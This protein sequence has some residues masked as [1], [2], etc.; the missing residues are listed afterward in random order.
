MGPAA[1][2]DFYGKLVEETPAK[3]DQD[4]L[5]VVIW[6]DP[7]VPD[8]SES[9]LGRGADPTPWLERGI[10]TLV[11]AGCNVLAV[12]CNTAHA[13]VP[14]LAR[15]AGIQLVSI[16]ETTVDAIVADGA[17]TVGLLA[18]TGTLR[19]RL[20]TD[21]L[22]RRHVAV[23]EP[24]P[25]DQERVMAA[26]L[27]VKGGRAGPTHQQALADVSLRLAQRGAKCLV[28]ACTEL[29]LALGTGAPIPVFDPARLLAR[30]VV[31]VARTSTS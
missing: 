19:S 3:S 29:V 9:L 5:P 1:T 18:T 26:I 7:H 31:A 6:A 30:R 28:A 16:V 10:R 17:P 8:R 15:Q 4:H 23:V 2:V 22:Q 21:A 12:P 13:F 14:R 20:Y 27:A 11:A 25:A 24:D